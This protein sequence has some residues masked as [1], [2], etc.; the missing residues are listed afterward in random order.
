MAI[1]RYIIPGRTYLITR[2]C[3]YRAFLLKPSAKVDQTFTYCLAVAAERY[4]VEVHGFLPMSNH[5]HIAITDVEGRLPQFLHWFHLMVARN[6]NVYYERQECF[7]SPGSYSAVHLVEPGDVLD[8]LAYLLSNPVAAGLV[9]H[10]TEWP[11]VISHPNDLLEGDRGERYRVARP[12]G[13]FASQSKLPEYAQVKITCPPTLRDRPREEVVR[14]LL[15]RREEKEEAARQRVSELGIRFLG[16][17]GI[18]GQSPFG[19]PNSREERSKLSPNVA[20][21]CRWRRIETLGGLTQ[22]RRE[23]WA[24]YLRFRE[25]DRDVV[26]PAGTWGPVKLYGARAAPVAEAA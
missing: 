9:R 19:R 4:G 20:C 24:C 1:P 5:H 26:F 23:Y 17:K 15:D 21:K 2:R 6:L 7:W 13:F 16:R 12:K 10:G 14:E 11:G 3:L 25:G 18:L 8:K 22:F